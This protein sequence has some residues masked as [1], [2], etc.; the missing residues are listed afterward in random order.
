MSLQRH[1]YIKIIQILVLRF[2]SVYQEVLKRNRMIREMINLQI[3]RKVQEK[4]TKQAQFQIY[5][6]YIH[7]SLNRFIHKAQITTHL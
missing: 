5:M 2:N 4:S 6:K 1:K 3:K 7:K